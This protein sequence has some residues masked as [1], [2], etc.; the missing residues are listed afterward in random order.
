M[1]LERGR[2]STYRLTTSRPVDSG[3]L[4]VVSLAQAEEFPPLQNLRCSVSH[5]SQRSVRLP[6]I[7]DV[8]EI[9]VAGVLAVHPLN[10]E[11]ALE[12]RLPDPGMMV[13]SKCSTHFCHSAETSTDVL[14]VIV[15][16][17]REAQSMMTYLPWTLN[18]SKTFLGMGL[19]S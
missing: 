3:T 1:I 17:S 14:S 19:F 9:M 7:G 13:A 6:L 12:V 10:F 18:I 4:G 11:G 5:L 8:L 16:S 15:L 2:H